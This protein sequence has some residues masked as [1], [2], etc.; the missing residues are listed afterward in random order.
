MVQPLAIL[1]AM[2]VAYLAISLSGDCRSC[3]MTGNNSDDRRNCLH[4][5]CAHIF[6]NE[7]RATFKGD[8]FAPGTR[9]RGTTK[10]SATNFITACTTSKNNS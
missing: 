7:I 6:D 4:G 9:F 3:P 10:H 1:L 8:S 5:E 2:S